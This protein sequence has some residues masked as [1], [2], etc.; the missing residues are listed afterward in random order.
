MGTSSSRSVAGRSD[1]PYFRALWNRVVITMLAIAFV[2]LL[3]IGGGLY[4]YTLKVVKEKGLETLKLE[5]FERKISVDR[6]LGERILALRQLGD[7]LGIESRVEPGILSAA[8]RSL[9]HTDG[10][11]T[12]LAVFD[13]RGRCLGF[14][15]PEA[16][17]D[18][19][20][21]L[22]GWFREAVGKGVSITDATLSSNGEPHVLMAVRV[23]TAGGQK[24]VRSAVNISRVDT[25]ASDRTGRRRAEGYL[26]NR[27]G[28]FQTQP[29]SAGLLMGRSPVQD[30]EKFDGIQVE[31][32]RDAVLLKIWQDR[33][34]WINVVQIGYRDMQSQLEGVYVFAFLV[35]IILAV[36]IIGIVLLTG[37][38]LA[39]R[40]EA[41]RS[42]LKVLDRQLRRASYMSSSMQVSLSCFNE[43]KEV[44]AN[45]DITAAVV[46]EDPVV[47]A[48][49]DIQESIGDIR[50]EAGRGQRSVE[51]F[52]QYIEPKPPLIGEAD[53]HG[54]LN[55]LMG[56]LN[57]ELRFRNITVRREFSSDLPGVRS[58]ASKLRQVFLNIVLNALEALEKDGEITLKTE[59]DIGANNVIVTIADNG[60]GIPE[61]DLEYVFE[62]LWTVRPHG[63]GLGLPLCRDILENLG[64]SIGIESTVGKGASVIV[65]IPLQLYGQT[66][67]HC[68]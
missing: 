68:D 12:D 48:S 34:P 2:P 46:L 51:S 23:R 38:D 28:I 49:T 4:W 11:F 66:L 22:A 20:L 3:L 52:L 40:L 16:V 31:E 1:F 41:K 50:S 61:A 56:I 47:A 33:V 43:V 39:S 19:D 65:T 44:L 59:T 67:Q 54:L 15:G 53:V 29:R 6:R 30:L 25:F 58:D 63:T 27:E 55:D 26:V 5:V 10:S 18:A 37:N 64:G 13:T 35:F 21:S 32:T 45:I 62:P 9:N 36:P 42:S 8:L 7:G 17:Q 14:V 57:R 24:I 60:P